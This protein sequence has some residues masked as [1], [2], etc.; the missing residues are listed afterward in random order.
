LPGESPSVPLTAV[1]RVGSYLDTQVAGGQLYEYRVRSVDPGGNPH[2]L[3]PEAT[4][5][6]L[7]RRA[8][9]WLPY[10]VAP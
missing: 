10:L 8:Q 3:S 2:Q 5:V 4:A 7:P 6:V 9:W 1:G